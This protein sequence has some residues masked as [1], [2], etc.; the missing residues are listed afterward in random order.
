M[1]V[2][3][4]DQFHFGPDLLVAPITHYEI[5][6][7]EVYLP[8][9]TDWTNA[10]TG[11]TQTGGQKIDSAAPIE[12]IPVFVRGDKTELVRLFNDLYAE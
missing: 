4:E 2:E 10:W 12:Q 8:T 1:A 6:N 3:I 9:G 11:E 5:R 7:R